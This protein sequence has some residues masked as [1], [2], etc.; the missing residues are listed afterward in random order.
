[1][2]TTVQKTLVKLNTSHINLFI[3]RDDDV[4]PTRKAEIE[5]VTIIIVITFYEEMRH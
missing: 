4:I 5:K 3:K 1:M 2:F